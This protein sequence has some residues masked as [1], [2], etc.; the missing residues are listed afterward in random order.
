MKPLYFPAE[1]SRVSYP[2]KTEGEKALLAWIANRVKGT[3]R[4]TED[5]VF[6]SLLPA[7]AAGVFSRERPPVYYLQRDSQTEHSER[8]C[9]SSCAAMIL[10]TYRPN[11][12][13]GTNGDDQYLARVLATGGDTVDAWAQIQALA[14]FGLK[15]TWSQG[16]GLKDLDERIEQ[17]LLTSTGILHH[18]PTS[19][20]TGGHHILPFARTANGYLCHDPFGELDMVAGTWA[21]LGNSV[22]TSPGRCVEYSRKNFAAR[23][24]PRQNDGWGLLVARP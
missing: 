6:L 23:W 3:Y 11:V 22:A 12:L 9:F 4:E 18:G 2:L 13:T 10:A 24:C 21:R 16:L 5:K 15:A 14:H 7:A 1:D 19:A 8:M 20:P 17:G